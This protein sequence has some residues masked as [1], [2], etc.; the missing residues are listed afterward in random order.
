MGLI[1]MDPPQIDSSCFLHAFYLLSFSTAYVIR[2]WSPVNNYTFGFTPKVLKHHQETPHHITKM[3]STSSLSLDQNDLQALRKTTTGSCWIHTPKIGIPGDI[4]P[5]N[6]K[7]LAKEASDARSGHFIRP[8][9]ASNARSGYSIRPKEASDACS[10]Y[11][12]RLR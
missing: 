9:E 3:D 12:R 4:P 11:S 10:G 5:E 1:P 6:L 2:L 8:K 7:V